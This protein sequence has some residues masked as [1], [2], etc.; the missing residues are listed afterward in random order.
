MTYGQKAW[1]C[2]VPTPYPKPCRHHPHCCFLFTHTVPLWGARPLTLLCDPF[3]GLPDPL[4]PHLAPPWVPDPLVSYTV[5]SMG[6]Q[7]PDFLWPLDHSGPTPFLGPTLSLWT[8]LVP[9]FPGPLLGLWTFP[10]PL[11]LLAHSEPLDPSGPTLLCLVSGPLWSHFIPFFS[12]KV[13]SLSL[14]HP[15]G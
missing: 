3:S 15:T 11:A 6:H 8:H 10:V 14:L 9:L 2:F 13:R 12:V 7:T 4:V 1:L 5:P